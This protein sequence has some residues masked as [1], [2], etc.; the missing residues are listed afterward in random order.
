MYLFDIK[1][2]A[3]DDNGRDLS[4]YTDNATYSKITKGA[5]RDSGMV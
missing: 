1:E 5:P 4:K 3:L 2:L